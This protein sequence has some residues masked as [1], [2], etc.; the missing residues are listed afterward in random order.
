MPIPIFPLP[1]TTNILELVS[2]ANA[3]S[4]VVEDPVTNKTADPE[5]VAVP[6]TDNPV[7]GLGFTVVPAYPIAIPGELLNP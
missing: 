7:P 6:L 4:F 1:L 2:E 5:V 3:S